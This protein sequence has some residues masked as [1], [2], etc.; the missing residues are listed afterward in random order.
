MP[1]DYSKLVLTLSLLK[2]LEYGSKELLNSMEAHI[3]DKYPPLLLLMNIN[4]LLVHRT[5]DQINF[6]KDQSFQDKRHVKYFR[7][8]T[9]VVYPRDGHMSF[10]KA[11]MQHPRVRFCFYSSIMRKN[12]MPVLIELFK[13]HDGFTQ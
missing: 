9:N 7:Q 12:I 4:G 8:G 2:H 6:V 11:V 5:K 1:D 3:K 10:L 13:D